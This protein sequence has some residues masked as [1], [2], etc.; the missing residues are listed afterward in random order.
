MK[1][2]S[3]RTAPARHQRRGER[4]LRAAPIALRERDR[5]ILDA[6]GKMR[7]LTTSLIA[8]L[9]FSGSRSA[10]NKRLRRLFDAGLVRAWVRD[11]AD[12]NVY[13]LT[14]AGH[15]VLNDSAGPMAPVFPCPRRLDG[16]L[17]HLLAINAVRAAF[18]VTLPDATIVWWH[19]DWDLRSFARRAAVPD[20]RFALH[21]P[22]G[23]ESTFALEVEYQTR[24]PRKFLTKMLRY[25][26]S[27][28]GP[29]GHTATDIVLVVCRHPVWLDRYR[30]ALAS[31]P[32]SPS[33]WFTTLAD[34][35]Q[36]GSGGTIWRVA[37]DESRYLLTDV[38]NRPNRT[39]ISRA[40][41][42]VPSRTSQ[43]PAAQICPSEPLTN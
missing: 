4:H 30:A 6:L 9:F 22:N 7:F 18:A 13:A 5:W 15:D 25:V 26:S 38:T 12:D 34:L 40:E 31:L 8:R 21:W 32:L 20:A 19:S 28:S 10:A 1:Q 41:N 43:P 27:R 3:V 2:N 17:D 36:H 42:V 16:R 23:T 29:L 14:P 11:L 24:T 33:V 37:G 39:A 35:E